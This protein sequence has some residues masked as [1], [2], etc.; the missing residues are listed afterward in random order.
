LRKILGYLI[1]TLIFITTYFLQINIF[2]NLTIFNIKP[3]LFIIFITIL[4]MFLCKNLGFMLG[5]IYGLW[6]DI[7]I[8][9]NLGIYALCLGL[10]GYLARTFY[11]K[12]YKRKQINSNDSNFFIYFS[13]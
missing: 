4:G 5:V 1:I 13:I 2:N 6:L 8:G 10:I 7:L 9:T 11:C 12:I 3:N